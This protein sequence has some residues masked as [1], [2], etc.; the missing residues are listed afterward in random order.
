LARRIGTVREVA[1]LEAAAQYCEQQ[2]L[3]LAK[4]LRSLHAKITKAS[5]ERVGVDI[6][7]I[8]QELVARS[9]GRVVSAKGGP[10]YWAQQSK[11]YAAMG[12]TVEDAQIVGDWLGKQAWLMT[13]YTIDSLAWK[14][15]NYLA[16]AK[17]EGASQESFSGWSRPEFEG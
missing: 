7:G 2:G 3:P 6:A 5:A 10:G 16:R 14:W 15:P 9:D 4:E 12:A 17:A 8:E 11:R 1:A 13:V